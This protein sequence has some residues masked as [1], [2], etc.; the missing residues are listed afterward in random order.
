MVCSNFVPVV[1]LF[2]EICQHLNFSDNATPFRLVP[3]LRVS[4]DE[5]HSIF[6]VRKLESL[7]GESSKSWVT[8]SRKP[9]AVP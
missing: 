5:I 4:S 1:M 7:G 9:T 6:G 3:G 8:A 2:I